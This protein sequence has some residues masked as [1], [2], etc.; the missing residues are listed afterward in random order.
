MTLYYHYVRQGLDAIGSHATKFSGD[1][2][3]QHLEN[4]GFVDV[5]VHTFKVPYGHWAKN[6]KLKQIGAT[7]MEV[8]KTGLEAHGLALMTQVLGLTPEVSK[9]VIDDAVDTM[10]SLK[11]HRYH[12]HW[13][14]YGRKPESE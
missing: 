6:K 12:V 7:A 11:E 9:K 5:H 4:A 2:F 3:K 8:C 1:F 10:V 14:I 13:N